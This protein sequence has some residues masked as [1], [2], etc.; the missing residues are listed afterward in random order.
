M[1]GKKYTISEFLKF[2]KIS[3]TRCESYDG[4][5]FSLPEESVNHNRI[6]NCI[7]NYLKGEILQVQSIA[8]AEN[9]KLEAERNYFSPDIMLIRELEKTSRIRTV[10]SP[11]LLG[12]VRSK[13]SSNSDRGYKLRQ[14]L[15]ISSLQYYMLVSQFECLVELYT[16]TEQE[17]FWTYQSF[18]KPESVI[19]CDLLNFT[20]PVSAIYE[21]I[22]FLDEE[23]PEFEI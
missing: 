10:R 8:I 3:G 11:I 15:Q 1:S 19:S 4:K 22:V 13:Y 12:Q 18:N 9:V 20:L 2:E 5:F 23:K 14:Y 6:V 16:R 21:G 17:G 7:K